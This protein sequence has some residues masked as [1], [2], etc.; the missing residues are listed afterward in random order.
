MS[1]GDGKS[2]GSS[3]HWLMHFTHVRNLPGIF[4]DGCL[5]ADSLVSVRSC[6][7]VEAGDPAIKAS[8]KQR[9]IMIRGEPYGCVGDYVPFYFANRSP[10]LYKIARGGVPSYTEGQDPLVYLVTTVETVAAAGLRW[11]FS[12]GNCAA[13]VTDFFDDLTLLDSAVD[14][15]VMRAQI[16]KNTADDPDKMRRRMAEFLVLHRLPVACLVGVVTQSQGTKA[17]V[18]ALLTQYDLRLPVQVRRGWYF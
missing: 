8:R 17:A 6:L 14:W 11:L 15:Q 9:Q 10:M 13:N 16:W 7:V 18:Q 2:L 4:S 12:D 1:T 5:Q 3:A